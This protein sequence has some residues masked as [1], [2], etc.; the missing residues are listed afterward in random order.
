MH[1]RENIA[2]ALLTGL[3]IVATLPLLVGT[4]QADAGRDAPV[5][6]SDDFFQDIGDYYRSWANTSNA[7]VSDVLG[8]P[9]GPRTWDFT[10][11]PSDEIKR[12]DYVPTDDGDDAGAGFFASVHYPDADFSQR[13][14]EEF[15][16]DQA[17][18]YLDQLAG[19]GRLNYG[20]YWPDGVAA[21]N[22]WSVFTPP[23]LDF[24]DPM[25]WGD[26]WFLS[27]EYQ[28]QMYDMEQ[29]LDVK[30][31]LTID[32]QVDA[33]G[34]V[35]LPTLGPIEALRVNTEQ[36]SVIY[37]WLLDQWFLISTQF[38]RIY[39][40]VGVDSDIV[41]EIGST[42]SEA[43]MPPD[44]FTLASI[45]VRQFENSNPTAAPEIAEIPD[46]TLFE[47]YA[48]F[49]YDVA[50]TG[51]PEPTF[52]LA[53][54]PDGMT[55]DEITGAIEWT[56]TSAQTGDNTVTVEADNSQGTDQ[57]TFVVTVVNLNEPPL[58]LANELFD[59]GTT[60]LF[61]DPPASTYWLA[62]YAVHHSTEIGGPY[63]LTASVESPGLGESNYYVVTA[64]IEVGREPYESVPS[65]EV[66]AYSLGVTEAGCGNDDGSAESGQVAGGANGEMAAS[67]ELPSEDELT[68]TKV[69][70]YLTEFV[71]APVTM[72]VAAD[73][74]GGLPGTSLYQATYPPS[75]L[76]A[77]WNILEIPEF[78]QPSF[79][80]GDFFVG[81]VEGVEY[82]TVGLDESAFG[83]SFTKAPGGA[84]SFLFSGELMFRGIVE[85]EG[86]GLD[87]PSDEVV[88]RLALGNFPDPFGPETQVSY[89]LPQPGR[90]T[91]RVYGVSGRLV[92]TLVDAESR[93]AG[94]HT[95]TWNGRDDAGRDAASGIYFCRLEVDGSVLTDKMILAK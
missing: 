27:T 94:S 43:S 61:W 4:S 35:I 88:S 90:V 57:E 62:G 79:T 45:F 36:T 32:A 17:W 92:R 2:R 38:I 52:S 11:G 7:S 18:M 76:R 83:H 41:A 95:V 34:T 26:S 24:P 33:W 93:E 63:E 42:V 81:A 80:G 1:R 9:G 87:D 77:G 84:W 78:L 40:W 74:A 16:G 47:T 68:L 31:E 75:M 67:L 13:M 30:V 21:T 85:S 10:E 20:F 73:D 3:L 25:T 48:L 55:I 89:E 39:D 71:D 54:A 59:T 65:N 60:E 5:L 29:V 53:V 6:T 51:I 70:V 19:S 72:K 86:T 69:A 56:P 8:L 82:N 28:F 12:F 64:K 37:V 66:L 22:D 23:L 46:A 14:T 15:G 44:Q 49:S 91:L 58:N 50:A